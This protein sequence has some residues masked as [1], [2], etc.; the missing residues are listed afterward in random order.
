MNID[1]DVLGVGV[2]APGLA[3]WNSLM[4]AFSGAELDTDQAANHGTLLSARDRRRAPS[5]VKLT[6][7]AAEQACVM[8]GIAPDEPIAIFS[9]SMGD[10]AISDYM[11]Q[12]LA[13]SPQQLSPTRFHNSV[14][15]AASGYWSI[16]VG[17]KGDITAL[18]GGVDSAT[19]GLIDALSRIG[20]TTKPVLV[21]IYDDIAVGPMRE[22]FPAN[23]PFCAALLLSRPTTAAALMKLRASPVRRQDSTVAMPPALAQRIEDNPAAR[24]LPL[25]AL[26]GGHTDAPITLGAEQGPGIEFRRR[27]L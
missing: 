6:F 27:M 1:V 19:V 23:Y 25:L 26:I 7:S 3:D 2:C 9:T 16:G 10:M 20:G 11:C 24:L 18:C 8:A 21:V 5:T 17:A 4:A 22:L 12:V 14:H 13:E 15:N